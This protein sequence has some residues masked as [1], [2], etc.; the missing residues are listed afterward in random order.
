MGRYVRLV[1]RVGGHD[2]L[3][4]VRAEMADP[5]SDSVLFTFELAAEEGTVMVLRCSGPAR[6]DHRRPGPGRIR[7]V[8]TQ[9]RIAA[10]G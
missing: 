2:A 8:Q 3:E 7:H 6:P 4:A 9:E 5:V 10:L 1:D